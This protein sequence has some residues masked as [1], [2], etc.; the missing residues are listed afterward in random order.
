MSSARLSAQLTISV[1]PALIS[2]VTTSQSTLFHMWSSLCHSPSLCCTSLYIYL[3]WLSFTALLLCLRFFSLPLHVWR[4]HRY[5]RR[6]TALQGWRGV[7]GWRAKLV[8]CQPAHAPWL[9]TDHTASQHTV[10]T[11]MA[12]RQRGGPEGRAGRATDVL[13]CQTC[14]R[15]ASA[16]PCPA[17]CELP[18]LHSL[19]G[20]DKYVFKETLASPC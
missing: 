18:R 16:L 11:A 19:S 4:N 14:Q 13:T 10:T 17:N 15:N 5:Q 12:S 3:R 9:Y 8:L 6:K 20:G 7:W 2:V 1:S